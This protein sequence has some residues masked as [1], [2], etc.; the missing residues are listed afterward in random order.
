MAAQT[1]TALARV[2]IEEGRAAD[3]EAAV[4]KLQQEFRKQ[5]SPDDELAAAVVLIQALLVQSKQIDAQHEYEDVDNLVKKTQNPF[6]RLQCALAG[7]RVKL[8]SNHPIE[9]RPLLI[10]I[11]EEARKRGFKGIELEDRLLQ[12]ELANKLGDH[13]AG[14][15]QL[16]KV[17]HSAQAQ[18]FGLISRRA[19]SDRLASRSA[20]NL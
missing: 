3:A 13:V 2:S 17:E 18:G 1:R 14:Q 4:R 16:A 6:A 15:D 19:S 5:K 8:N 20:S 11:D 7:A 10:Q 12:A 9:S